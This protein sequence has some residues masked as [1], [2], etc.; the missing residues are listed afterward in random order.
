[1][2]VYMRPR[3]SGKSTTIA[4]QVA[5]CALFDELPVLVIFPNQQAMTHWVTTHLKAQ[6]LTRYELLFIYF[7]VA[8]C[9]VSGSAANTSN[10]VTE[11]TRM[12]PRRIYL[13]EI[14]H[15]DAT[16]IKEL[17]VLHDD[18]MYAYGTPGSGRLN[19]YKFTQDNK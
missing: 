14:G 5:W 15:M 13:D 8:P 11:I 4:E 2:T 10:I 16:F 9:T 3:Q 19:C 17:Q 6:N 18:I 1:M 7:K 12:H